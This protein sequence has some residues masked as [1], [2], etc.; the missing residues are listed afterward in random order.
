[1]TNTVVAGSPS[2]MTT[3]LSP[4][5]VPTGIKGPDL[6]DH[7]GCTYLTNVALM[8]LLSAAQPSTGNPPWAALGRSEEKDSDWIHGCSA[9]AALY[10]MPMA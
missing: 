1:M 5:Q 10:W 3:Y 6:P 4:R 7:Y 2:G 8:L 9:D